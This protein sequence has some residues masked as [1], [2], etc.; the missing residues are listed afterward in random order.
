MQRQETTYYQGTTPV[1]QNTEAQRF[2]QQD[3]LANRLQT[4]N[5]NIGSVLIPGTDSRK[6]TEEAAIA[7]SEPVLEDLPEPPP[8][9][10]IP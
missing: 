2:S 7:D 4:V 9:P 1:Q 6:P 10:A 8:M 3:M 5:Q